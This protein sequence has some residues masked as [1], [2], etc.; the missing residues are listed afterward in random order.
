MMVRG[1]MSHDCQSQGRPSPHKDEQWVWQKHIYNITWFCI[2][3][4][5]YI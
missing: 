1:T 2:S 3:F 5:I 4:T